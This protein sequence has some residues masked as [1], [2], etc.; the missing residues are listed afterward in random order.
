MK[1]AA[2]IAL[3]FLFG[4]TTST[5]ITT[6]IDD[7]PVPQGIELEFRNT[8]WRNRDLTVSFELLNPPLFIGKVQLAPTEEWM[9][10]LVERN[11]GEQYRITWKTL[12]GDVITKQE[13]TVGKPTK[14]V[15]SEPFDLHLEFDQ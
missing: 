1:K 6:C 9:F 7:P 11:P 14:K 3:L 10:C 15:Y 4:C 8:D 5:S 13:F 12:S 2:L